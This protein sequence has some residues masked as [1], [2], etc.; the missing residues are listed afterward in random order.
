MAFSPWLTN[1]EETTAIQ[2]VTMVQRY[3]DESEYCEYINGNED[4][5]RD[6]TIMPQA[7][8]VAGEC[9]FLNSKLWES[10]QNHCQGSYSCSG[11]NLL[12]VERRSR[13][14]LLACI[15]SISEFKNQ[16]APLSSPSTPGHSVET[17]C[18]IHY[19][20]VHQH[21]DDSFDV[22]DISSAD[23]TAN[24][25]TKSPLPLAFLRRI[26]IFAIRIA[27]DLLCGHV[28]TYTH[29]ADPFARAFAPFNSHAHTHRINHQVYR[30]PVWLGKL[31]H[32][33]T[34]AKHHHTTY[35]TPSSHTWHTVVFGN[36]T[37]HFKPL[38]AYGDGK[39]LSR[40]VVSS[41]F[42]KLIHLLEQLAHTESIIMS[43]RFRE[44][45]NRM[46]TW[47]FTA[48]MKKKEEKE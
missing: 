19:F 41:L 37:R 21:R 8:G 24:I 43:T 46:S 29:Q 23:I 34:I 45:A 40:H 31:K 38:L 20:F 1:N 36:E 39:L 48:R 13:S 42:V 27:S 44:T 2:L 28:P 30:I 7:V 32:W 6:Y 16:G 11:G 14:S 12:L 47:R 10:L 25:C 35:A 33:N 9:N 17:K 26:I 5:E 15:E 18:R 4:R 22:G 3:K